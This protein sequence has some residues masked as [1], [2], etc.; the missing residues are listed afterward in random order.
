MI[1]YT[2]TSDVGLDSAF[3]KGDGYTVNLKWYKAWSSTDQPIAYYLYYSTEKENVFSDGV[4][5]ISFDGYTEADIVDLDP[6]QLYYFSV[7]PIEYDDILVDLSSLPIAYG[8]L[9]FF[10]E[11]LLREDITDESLIIPLLDTD[12]FP[13]Y[14]FVKIGTELIQYLSVDR[15]N[16]DLILNDISNRGAYETSVTIHQMDGYDGYAYWSPSVTYSLGKES[17]IYDRV[18]ACQNRIDVPNYSYTE[19]DGYKQIEKDLLTS[20]LSGS[21]EYNE[22]FNSYDY[23]GWHRTDPV[24]LVSGECVGSYLSGEQFCADGYGGVGR[25]VRGIPLQERAMQRQEYLLSITGEPV[26]LLRRKRTGVICKCVLPTSEYPDDRCPY[27]YGGKFVMGYDQYFN[28]RRSD[29]RIMV[30]FSNTDEDVKMNEAGLESEFSTDCW[31]LTVPT[32]KDRDILVRFDQ[33]GNEEYRY[34]V[35]SVNRNK[36]VTQLQGA[37]K[38]KVQRIRKFDKAYQI[39]VFRD[40]STLPEKINTSITNAVGLG[41]HKHEI[42]T[43]NKPIYQF[44]QL[45]SVNQ[46]HNHEVV[47][48]SNTGRL[49]VLETLGHTH[50][51]IL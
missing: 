31:T 39:K 30:R 9:K 50:D 13:D 46:G 15:V 45:T 41:L 27:C 48:N 49:E 3:S 26:V 19:T 32:V 18:Y 28:P 44:N 40:T 7:R 16:H 42:V 10:P 33:D 4:K 43:T 51:L 23:D 22:D 1:F 11:S 25:M 24:K 2:F 14:G 34:E 17:L 5:F 20:D 12:G 35:L 37:Q 21:D 38:I 8:N 6:G 29:G 47:W 36:T